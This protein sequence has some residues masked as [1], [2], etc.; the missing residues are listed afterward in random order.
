MHSLQVFYRP[1]SYPE[2]VLWK[3]FPPDSFGMIGTRGS[4]DLGG[5]PTIRPGFAPKIPFG[6]PNDD[7]DPTTGRRLRRGFHFQVR[8][9]GKGHVVMER[10][11]LHAQRLVENSKGTKN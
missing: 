11:R 2:W 8:I 6:K 5:N 9:K 3:D 1:D 10:F 7:T 4:L